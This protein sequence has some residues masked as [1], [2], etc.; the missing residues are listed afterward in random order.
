MPTP[1]DPTTATAK[2]TTPAM[3]TPATTSAR[4][5]R[6][7]RGLG[8]GERYARQ[9]L[10]AGIGL[11]GQE[12]IA[13]G[14]VLIVGCGALGSVL[15]NNL[16][17]AGVGHL[18][19]ADRDYV[20]GNNLQRQVLYVEDDVRRGM[21]KAA[22]AAEY[23]RRVNGLITIEPLVT[24]VTAENVEELIEGVDLVLDGTDN[25]ETRYLLND[26]CLKA[27]VPWIY[28]GVIA[29]YGVTLAVLPGETA[30]LRCV[31]PERPLPGTT[32]TCDTAG[33][34]NGIV[35]VIAG[36]ASTEAL[37]LLVGSPQLVRGMTWVDLWENTFDR[38][39]LPRQPDCPACGR[40]EYEY[41]DAP[42]DESGTALCGR[43]A[44]Q[45]RPPRGAASTTGLDL[46]ALAER[47]APVGEVASNSFLL[48]L[49]VDGY[50]VTVFPDARAIIK[51]TDDLALARSVYAK[52]VGM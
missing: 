46:A 50:D 16:A 19:I 18:R 26:A 28:S 44:V 47:L 33:V 29:A 10:F 31:F 7:E 37:K 32:P 4:D 24:D 45:V 11:G 14:R 15:A 21:P 20:E 48:R 9:T 38:I 40:G 36:M 27:G 5:E 3:S 34:L 25:F 51:G 12:R 41:L 43:N 23:L 30:C 13:R 52:Y 35:G 42:I 6:A 22:A 17:R 2:Q 8:A 1:S 49:R 39:E